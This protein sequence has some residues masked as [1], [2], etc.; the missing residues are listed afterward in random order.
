MAK[1]VFEELG[2]RRFEWKCHNGNDASKRAA[3]RFGFT[4]E[5]VFRNDMVMKGKNRDT[6]WF[7]MIDAE[8]PALKT[9]Y[10]AWLSPDNFDGSGQQV[11]PLK[12]R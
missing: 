4:F 10:N 9:G 5:G 1:H 11:R 6:A 3:L 12:L 2:Y 7:S 8:W